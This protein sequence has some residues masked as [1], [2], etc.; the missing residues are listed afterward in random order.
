M[1][2]SNRAPAFWS[3][4][5]WVGVATG[6]YYVSQWAA[7]GLVAKLGNP[8]TVGIYALAIAIATPIVVIS[9]MQLRQV[10]VTATTP[11]ARF[12]TFLRTRA[13]L[14]FLA[15][16]V[17]LL[18]AGV[19]RSDIHF[20]S[21]VF[22]VAAIRGVEGIGDIS[23]GQLQRNGR[24]SEASRL[25]V[26]RT[27][28]GFGVF[29]L[30]YKV[31]H[32]LEFALLAQFV[33]SAALVNFIEVPRARQCEPSTHSTL[34]DGVI[35]LVGRSWP[36]SLAAAITAVSTQL[37]R[38]IL[39]VSH[40]VNAV[41]LFS[42][43]AIPAAIPMVF[44]AAVSQAILRRLAEKFS[45]RDNHGF[46]ALV[47]KVVSLNLV[48]GLAVLTTMIF[49]GEQV[50]TLLASDDYVVAASTSSLL[51]VYFVLGAFGLWGSY[52]LVVGQ[53]FAYQLWAALGMLAAQLLLG[54]ILI[55]K[56]GLEGAALT[57]CGKQ[58]AAIALLTLFA[59][60]SNRRR[61]AGLNGK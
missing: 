61:S 20:V 21:I 56:Y 8:N 31:A 19:F 14:A 48:V 50:L 34:A 30:I 32:S 45:S 15:M 37:P 58:I 57:E 3:P 10:L 54:L 28:V 26:T 7:I 40:G 12:T 25:L 29:A 35:R 22:L 43:A 47:T 16:F 46:N 36:L 52:F 49:A 44:Q 39:D 55:P 1:P 17:T 41:A 24:L 53:E 59:R 11:Q 13:W 5:V 4:T 18:V 51:S 9:Q 60:V 2:N 33:V 23:H 38:Y 27:A 6:T 42:I